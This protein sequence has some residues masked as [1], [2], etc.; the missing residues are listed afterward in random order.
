[1]KV[2]IENENLYRKA[3][4]NRQWDIQELPS[5]VGIELAMAC[6][7]ECPMCPVPEHTAHMDRNTGVMSRNIYYRIM[8]QISGSPKIVCLNQMGEPL[9][10]KN[11]VEYVQAAKQRGHF[12]YFTNNGTLLNEKMA[13][14]LLAAGLDQVNFSFE[15]GT[16]ETYEEIRINGKFEEVVQNINRFSELAAKNKTCRVRVDMLMTEKTV[17]EIDKFKA[18]WHPYI[19][20]SINKANNWGG[21]ID[22]PDGFIFDDRLQEETDRYPCQ[23]LWQGVSISY[24]GIPQFCCRDYKLD[25]K[26]SS[27]LEK[28]LIDIWRDEVGLERKRQVEG[29]FSSNACGSCNHWRLQ[30]S[31]NDLKSSLYLFFRNLR[32]NLK[33]LPVYYLKAT[34]Q[35][36]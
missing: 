4:T 11:I 34:G 22:V 25:S 35:V 13:I 32:T 12:V 7:L 16:K 26:L 29:D 28:D 2:F 30:P 33:A 27:I 19:Y 9:L 15:G 23:L 21:G 3:F 1:M 31:R 20:T 5:R 18:L 8:D 6:N 36:K 10:N 17:K 14:D 24:E